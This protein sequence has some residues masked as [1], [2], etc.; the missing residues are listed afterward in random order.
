MKDSTVGDLDDLWKK[1]RAARAK[2]E[3][4]WFMCLAFYA[5]NQWVAWDGKQLFKPPMPKNRITVV[6][7]RIQPAVRTEIARLTRSRPIFTV[8]PNSADD[9]DV[10]ASKLGEGIMK[11]VWKHLNLQELSL[12]AVHWSRICGAG[13][14][15]CFWDSS[16]GDSTEVLMGPGG[17]VLQGQDG[18][19]MKPG[20][21]PDIPGVVV[22]RISQGDLRVEVRSPFQMFVD[23]LA[24]SFSEA[25]WVI[26]E[27]V[28]SAEYVQR[29]YGVEVTPDTP[30]NP[31]LVEARMGGSTFLPGQT[32]YKGVKVRE[33]WCKPCATH[34]EGRRAVWVTSSDGRDGKRP[35]SK[36][37]LE[38]DKPF[39][40]MPY[41]MLKGI[42]IPGRLWP[43][44]V[45][46][47]LRG[48]QT[49]LNKLK[50][51]IAENRN[52]VGNPTIVA[53]EQAV[54]DPDKF[55][56]SMTLPGG[57]C[58]ID[59]I[60]SPN[61]MPKILEAPQL[62][63]YVV[64]EIQR[65]EESIA[66]I[67][68]QH[69]VTSAQVPPGVTAASAI[70]LLQESDNTRLAP[71]VYDY[72]QQ[73]GKLGQKLLKLVGR[74]Y[75]DARTIRLG[76]D[77]GAWEIFDFRGAMLRENSHVEVQAGSAFPQ[78]KAAK[79]AAMQDLLTFFVQSGQ[80]PQGRQLAQFLK[81][82][83]VGGAERLIEEYT[84]DE[85]QCN[86]E[87]VLMVQ[88]TVV[89]LNEF[90][91]DEAHI[92]FH[93]DFQKGPRYQQLPPNVQQSFALHVAAHRQRLQQ[94]Q[95]QQLQTQ[96]QMQ[97]QMQGGGPQQQAQDAQ[98]Q[99]QAEEQH[100]VGLQGQVQQQQLEADQ[101]AHQQGLKEDQ[102]AQQQ[103]LQQAG[104]E[105][106]QRHAE[107]VHQHK[108]SQ[109]RDEH[110]QKLRQA[111]E[112]HQAQLQ[113]QAVQAQARAQATERTSRQ[114]A[115]QRQTK[116][117]SSANQRK[118]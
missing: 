4:E 59:D 1:A 72:E 107:E 60:G 68:G 36:L 78:S 115:S 91:N 17:N 98:G 85:E 62:P 5:G 38:D 118:R 43:T 61:A 3:P 47:Q 40:P 11:Y 58:W 14:L 46:E 49:E 99:Q 84:L 13:F 42:E 109:L 73:L 96:I 51:Q 88:G 8:S 116:E 106:G 16:L 55:V 20:M 33:Y 104:Q 69:E 7:N 114:Q 57:V 39:D 103:G 105:Q 112:Q 54:R 23:P 2:L 100:Q 66:E 9:M 31:G 26:E 97:Q 18:R 86:R 77:N 37:L 48:P 28:K 44:S 65:I 15:K 81:D 87:N 83:E 63:N 93:Q 45:A 95:Q 74:Y 6:D 53:S 27:S 94:M 110:L 108:L 92:A 30:A 102:H 29:R 19:P 41:V 64:E 75:T 67:S 52:R 12:K 10:N 56:A 89:K 25:E 22:K 117:Q 70:N 32:A 71:A 79:Q 21:L 82:W 113:A 90:D 111:E 34:P 76:G 35:N 80:P 101:Q 24:D 50:S